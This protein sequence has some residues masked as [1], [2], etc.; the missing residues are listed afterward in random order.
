MCMLRIACSIEPVKIYIRVL[1][2]SDRA[3]PMGGVP[4]IHPFILSPGVLKSTLSH[5]WCRMNLPIFLSSVGL[6]TLI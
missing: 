5:I 4:C 2:W 3:C 6:F 1:G